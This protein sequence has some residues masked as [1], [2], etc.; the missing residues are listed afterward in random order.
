MPKSSDQPSPAFHRDAKNWTVYLLLGLFSFML[1]MIGPM[2]PFLREEYGMGYALA[3]LHQTAFALGM[4]LM[5]FFASP[6]IG[7]LGLF[8]S[9][10]GG[11]ADMLLGLL[12]MI[13]APNPYL[14]LGG[15]F[16]MSL[17]GTLALAAIQTSF[18]AVP[19]IHRGKTILEAN[20]MASAF[21]MLVPLVLLVGTALG[22]GWRIVFPVMLLALGATA[23]F[24]LG[25]TRPAAGAGRAGHEDEG[26]RLGGAYFRMWVLLLIGVSVEW[27]IGFWCMSY[28]LELPGASRSL[29]AAGTVTLGLA[30]V[31]GRFMAS[32]LGLRFSDLRLLLFS[33]ALVAAGFPFYWLLPGP[34]LA[35][36]GLVFCGFGTA[37]FY[38][39][40]FSLA[41]SRAER[42]GRRASSLA[43]IASG[44]AIA[45]APWILGR[46]GDGI[47]MK[48][49]LLYVPLGLVV[50]GSLLL[51]DASK[52]VRSARS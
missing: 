26:G 9:L 42:A 20:V 36:L 43:P 23:T 29:A 12:V 47:G 1:T 38:P 15:I 21:T 8:A 33:M 4:I 2:V 16:L 46:L 40:I 25:A 13:L 37:N 39:L 6:L 27:S 30:A 48:A 41:L 14:T 11:M 3:G 44:L 45:L 32:R 28:L 5:G 35:F 51:F 24:G 34:V 49:A 18:S 10:W 52:V 7:R 22:M 50:M 31:A 17:G 19:A